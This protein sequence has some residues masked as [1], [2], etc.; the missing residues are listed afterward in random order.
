[1]K[2][3]VKSVRTRNQKLKGLVFSCKVIDCTEERR[4]DIGEFDFNISTNAEPDFNTS[5]NAETDFDTTATATQQYLDTTEPMECDS[6]YEPI[7]VEEPEVQEHSASKDIMVKFQNQQNSSDE[8]TLDCEK[9]EKLQSVLDRFSN[10]VER[11]LSEFKFS[12]RDHEPFEKSAYNDAID[13]LPTELDADYIEIFY[14]VI[15]DE[16]PKRAPSEQSTPTPKAI[17]NDPNEGYR[18][19]FED[20]SAGNSELDMDFVGNQRLSVAIDQIVDVMDLNR[21]NTQFFSSKGMWS[22]F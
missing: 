21:S 11:E 14:K 12:N 13:Q 20:H 15:D 3:R 22:F 18:I 6:E 7:A 1:M 19:Q 8:V 17:K 9:G 4:S 2:E 16:S 5:M 10:K